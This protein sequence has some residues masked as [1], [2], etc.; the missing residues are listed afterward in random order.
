MNY[1]E[2][3]EGIKVDVQAVDIHIPDGVQQGIRDAITKLGK[4][5][6]NIN[7]VDVYLKIQDHQTNQK[8]LRMR[9]GVPGPDVFAEDSGDN[10]A[11]LLKSVTEKLSRQLEKAK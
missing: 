6:R 5:A 11:P 8:S 7:F 10:W 1:T 9:V 4:H 2:N 3:F